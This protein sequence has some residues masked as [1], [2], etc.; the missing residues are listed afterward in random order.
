MIGME[1]NKEVFALTDSVTIL[2]TRGSVPVSGSKYAKYGG[3][4]SSYLVRL[5]GETVVLDGG[6]GLLKIPESLLSAPSLNLLLS[7][8]H[9]DHLHG[10]GVF[11]FRGTLS[12]YAKTRGGL[13]PEEQLLR[14]YSPPLWPVSPKAVYR[15]LE[16]RFTL[17]SIAVETAEGVHPGGVSLIKLSGGGKTV[18][19]A[20]DTTLTGASS[21]VS[22][23]ADC[24]LLLCDG[25]FCRAEW[26]EK[27]GW[28]HSAWEDAAEAARAAGARKLRIIHHSPTR[29]DSELDAFSR[30][31]QSSGF[32]WAFAREGEEVEL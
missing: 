11:P 16:E 1:Y 26:S 32:D 13:S 4:T 22:F 7:H 9:A 20:S 28:G 8:P 29:T 2:G 24:D 15:E 17:G 6:T 27:R 30:K 23:A 25:Q 19:Y 5:A 18:V 3:A 10:L 14:Y 21:L 31:L 12:I